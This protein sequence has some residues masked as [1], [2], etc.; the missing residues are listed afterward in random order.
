MINYL[1]LFILTVFVLVGCQSSPNREP[2]S[3]INNFDSK[4]VELLKWAAHNRILVQISDKSFQHVTQSSIDNSCGTLGEPAWAE[5]VM[6]T[7]QTLQQESK[8]SKLAV[9]VIDIRPG[10]EVAVDS[11]QDL[12]GLTYLTLE[13]VEK[14]VSSTIT[15]IHQIPC[16]NRAPTYLGQTRVDLT[17]QIPKAA[18]IQAQLKKMKPVK[19]PDRWQFK[20]DFL[21]SLAEK[22]TIFRLTP[23]VSFEKAF[24]GESLIVHFMNT[25]NKEIKSGIPKTLTYWLS[26]INQRSHSGSYL[27]LFSLHSD[28]N[29]SYGI[30]TYDSSQGVAYPF[31][32]Y[33][34][35][36]GRFLLTDLNQLDRCL[37]DLTMRY[38]RSLASIGSDISTSSQSFL[39]PGFS[40]R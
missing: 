8:K 17:F 31:M 36:A 25:M 39:A 10:A 12:D 23:D 13:Y 40:C 18:D 2:S 5:M 7:L 14:S 29:M 38:R 15:D 9:H 4:K 1:G 33:K 21:E 32:S 22:M 28:R 27:N 30:G 16:E 26:E 11:T 34:I 20:T 24:D 3:Q 19:T 6:L 35:E 37:S